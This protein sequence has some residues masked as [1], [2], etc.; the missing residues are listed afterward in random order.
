MPNASDPGEPRL[1]IAPDD[2]A[3]A[4][5]AADYVVRSLQAALAARSTVHLGLTGGSTAIALYR[6]LARRPRRE[7]VDWSRIHLWWGDERLV[8]PDHPQSNAGLV[9]AAL[10]CST[11]AAGS[12]DGL[13]GTDVESEGRPGVTVP[14]DQ[15]HPIP[16]AQSLASTTDVLAA[17]N[18]AADAYAGELRD[19]VPA[20]PDGWPIFDL[21]LLGIGPDGHIL[22]CFPG[23][24][25]LAEG[26]P[27]A[28][29]IP[30]PTHVE[31]HLARVTLNPRVVPVARDVA[32]MAHGEA[33]ADTLAHVMVDPR[34][35]TVY[36]AVYARRAGATWFL[37]EACAAD[38]PSEMG[39][40]R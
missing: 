18:L 32:V 36:P 11:G 25:A 14:P 3:V 21:L 37:D 40:R 20:S 28:L 23:S 27:V 30:A 16:V 33:K 12:G 5:D 15:I 1:V 10:L 35:A 39:E 22:S 13:A 38:M 6:L 2:E 19:L 8:P 24:P 26:A 34:D 4:I 31:P 17:A 7:A 9:E 29:G